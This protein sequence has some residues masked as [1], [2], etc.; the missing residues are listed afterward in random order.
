MRR[1][2]W[3]ELGKTWFRNRHSGFFYCLLCPKPS[4]TLAKHEEH[5]DS[6]HLSAGRANFG[7]VK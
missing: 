7:D 2:K 5:Y 3:I 1:M 6:C 4:S